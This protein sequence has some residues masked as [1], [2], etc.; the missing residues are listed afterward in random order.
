MNRAFRRLRRWLQRLRFEG[1]GYLGYW[2]L[3]PKVAGV[4]G[5]VVRETWDVVADGAHNSNTDLIHWNGSFYLCH[6]TSPY[7]MGS[8]RSR[9]LLWRSNDARRW[10]RVTA[11]KAEEGEYRD[12]KFAAIH[13]RLFLFALP[14][15]DFLAE[16]LTT[17]STSSPDGAVWAPMREVDQPGW[18]YWRPKTSDGVTWY[19]TA[20]WHEHGRSMLFRS[21]DGLSWTPVSQ[22]YEGERN[23]ETDFEFLPD[24]RIIAT[25]RLEGTG[26]EWG[27][28]Q[29]GTLIAV[30]APPYERWTYSRSA[31]TRLDGPC[32]FPYNGRIY[33]IGRYQATR[34]LRFAEQGGLYSKKRTSLFLVEESGL[35]YLTDL[36]S[37]GDTSYAGVVRVGDELYVS[38]YTSP[39]DR[40]ATW[41]MGMLRP[42]HIRLARIDLPALERLALTA[43]GAPGG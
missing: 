31:V 32:L 11:F 15:R 9:L 30:A 8:S 2:L 14:N 33:A 41:I 27:D 36:P 13:D 10:E 38:Y 34:A 4:D 6:Q 5:R 21:G 22:I 1:P 12:P 7:H 3:R 43:L 17:V 16:P 28:A 29:A 26:S 39:L 20:Y 23:D 37:A 24:G 19:V 42:S 35:R 40:D 18:L 25:A